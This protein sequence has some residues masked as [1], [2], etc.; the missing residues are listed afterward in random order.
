MKLNDIV[1]ALQNISHISGRLELI[2]TFNGG[3]IY[4]DYAHTP[5]ALKNS[6][7]SLREYNP[8]KI[9]T[10]FGCGGDRDVQKRELMG[11]AAEKYSDEVIVT[12]DNPRNEDPSEI[13]KMVMAG[14]KNAK[15]IGDRKLAIEFAMDM[16][17]DNDCLLVAGKG[18]ESYQLIKNNSVS[19]SDK[20]V[21]LG[22]VSKCK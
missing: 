8:E 22:K 20:D 4:L 7:L 21:I 9:I 12:D 13:R 5:D 1:D 16:L 17:S 2:R 6:I 18:H 19:F 15:E 14:C 11:V 3:K 10:V